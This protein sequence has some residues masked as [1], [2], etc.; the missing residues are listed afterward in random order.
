MM[1]V[2]NAA[3]YLKES[4]E[5]IWA[6]VFK[7]FEVVVVDD[8]SRDS[9]WEL[10]KAQSKK[11]QRLRVFRHARNMGLAVARN[12]VLLEAKAPFLAI[13]DA[14]DKARPERLSTQM[15]RMKE[16]PDLGVLGTAVRLFGAVTSR[17]VRSPLQD[18]AIRAGL[19]FQNLIANSSAMIRKSALGNLRYREGYYASE[20]YDLWVRLIKRCRM[21]NLSEVLVDYRVHSGQTGP[22]KALQQYQAA[23][24]IRLDYLRSLGFKLTTKQASLHLAACPPFSSLDASKVSQLRDLWLDLLRQ[25]EEKQLLDN[26]Q[27][28]YWIRKHF[29]EACMG[30][31]PRAWLAYFTCGGKLRS[32]LCVTSAALKKAVKSLWFK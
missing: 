10:L 27:L 9:S 19:A 11:D 2:Y 14:D 7:N 1:P 4:L 17:V 32:E 30:A 16:Q 12:R 21:A 15:E 3:A 23:S 26:I 5:S 24:R 31:G 13:L 8:G 6:Q 22:A 20:D 18:S 29:A 28:L 25:N